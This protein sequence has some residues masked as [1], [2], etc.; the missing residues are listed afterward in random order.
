ME[1]HPR[2]LVG[3]T[4]KNRWTG[5]EHLIDKEYGGDIYHLKDVGLVPIDYLNENY[6]M[7]RV[8]DWGDERESH[9]QL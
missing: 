1:E 8:A 4:T 6:I 2:W 3:S 7:S 9:R 5:K